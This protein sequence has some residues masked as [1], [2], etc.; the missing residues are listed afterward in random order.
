MQLYFNMTAKKYGTQI[1][2]TDRFFREYNTRVQMTLCNTTFY[3]KL[4]FNEA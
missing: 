1:E 2:E 4:C 3:N